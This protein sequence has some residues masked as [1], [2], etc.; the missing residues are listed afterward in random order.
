MTPDLI[1]QLGDELYRALKDCRT[2]APL[3]ERHPDI[4]IDDAYSI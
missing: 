1:D 3:T 2:L 4:G